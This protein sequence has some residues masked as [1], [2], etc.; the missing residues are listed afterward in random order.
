VFG[1][2]AWE[3]DARR[4]QYYLHNFLPSQPDFNFH[5][6]DVQDWHL[7]TMRFWLDRGVD[8][9]RLDTVNYYFHDARLRSNPPLRRNDTRPAVNPYDM[10]DHLH[11]K[12]QP[13][14]I[15]FLQRAR[16]LLDGYPDRVMV[17]EVG[18]ADRAVQ[19]MGE[20]TRGG[21]RLH[22]AYS[23]EL[24]G[25]PFTAAH[26]RRA[27]EGF[28]AGAPDGWPCWAFSNHD[29][30]RHLSRWAEHGA[31]DDLG[32]L[33][34]ALLLSLQGSICLY[35][36][37]E[38]GQTETDIEFHELTDPPGFAFWPDYKG[39]DG[40]RTPMVW[41]ATDRGG[42]TTG[43]PWLPVKAPQLARNLAAQEQEGSVLH[44]YREMLAFRRG[45]A[46]RDGGSTFATTPEPILAF[47]R[48]EGAGAIACLFNLSPDPV[49]MRASG[50]LVGPRQAASVD[51]P[52]I[53]LGPNGFAFLGARDGVAPGIG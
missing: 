2:S 21:D 22:M 6:P 19:V 15:A 37:E 18:E 12:T 45:S 28:F 31:Q 25:P 38:L 13:E 14:T 26:V 24:L 20:Y 42:F 4:R 46:L 9:F 30:I 7:E 48:G 3:W 41:D 27:V 49:T 52:T 23:F 5:T 11:S 53:R 34:A 39:R 43:T 36:G 32:R 50:A 8:G 35:Q 44:A 33:C 40:C 1:G 10:Q 16:A 29:V 17:G 47:L 51:G